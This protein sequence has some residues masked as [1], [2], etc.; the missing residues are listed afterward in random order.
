MRTKERIVACWLRKH[1]KAGVPF[2]L[3][4]EPVRIME[5]PS[6]LFGRP[7]CTVN[8]APFTLILNRLVKM[9]FGDFT[10]GNKFTNTRV[11]ENNFDSPPYNLPTVS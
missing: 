1:L 6:F 11:G 10:D 5:P 7:L 8:S 2:T 9:L 4:T 3:T